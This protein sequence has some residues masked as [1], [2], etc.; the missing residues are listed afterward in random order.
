MDLKLFED[1]LALAE[2]RKSD[3]TR[4]PRRRLVAGN[5]GPARTGVPAACAR[6]RSGMDIDFQ[7]RIFRPITRPPK[8]AERLWSLLMRGM[9]SVREFF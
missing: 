2:T 5:L 3:G 8:P 9:P 7:V 1:F 6:W 4:R